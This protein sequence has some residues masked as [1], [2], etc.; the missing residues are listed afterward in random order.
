MVFSHTLQLLEMLK[1]GI[2][3][4]TVMSMDSEE[5]ALILGVHLGIKQKQHDDQME[6]GG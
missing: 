1:I 3:Y 4:D 6:A 5:T 2:P